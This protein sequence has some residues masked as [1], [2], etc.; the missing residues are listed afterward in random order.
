MVVLVIV[1]CEAQQ[2]LVIKPLV[3]KTVTQLKLPVLTPA[4]W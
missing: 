2:A 1:Y 3:E 4:R